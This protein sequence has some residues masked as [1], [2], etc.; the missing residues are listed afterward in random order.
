MFELLNLDINPFN[1][2]LNPLIQ[3]YELKFQTKAYI[4]IKL[5]GEENKRKIQ[6]FKLNILEKTE[7]FK[8]YDL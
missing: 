6:R 7:S 5:L 3:I 1:F 2:T 8:S 4:R